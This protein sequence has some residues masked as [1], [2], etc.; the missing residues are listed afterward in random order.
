[1][2]DACAI[3]GQRPKYRVDGRTCNPPRTRAKESAT[4]DKNAWD[5]KTTGVGARRGMREAS[6]NSNGNGNEP[7]D[8]Q[9]DAEQP[10]R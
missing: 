4:A 1:M 3:V 2:Y 6:E 8:V 10:T 5:G 7:M 9:V